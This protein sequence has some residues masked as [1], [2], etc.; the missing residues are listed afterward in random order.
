ML[1]EKLQAALDKKNSDITRYV[2]KGRK[3]EVNGQYV[4]TEKRL[5]DCSESE[6]KSFYAHCES[7]LH[8]EN[9]ENPGRHVLLNIVK[10]QI[11][12]CNAELFLRY[13]AEEPRKMPKFVF[14]TKIRE[15]LNNNPH[16]DPKEYPIST[17]VGSC[18][19]EYADIPI[20]LVMDG[21]LERLG[22]FERKH[23]TLTFI[24]KQGIWFTPA[25]SKEI[26]EYREKYNSAEKAK[27]IPEEDKRYLADKGSAAKHYLGLNTSVALKIN[28]KGL[29]LAQM[30]AMI[31]LTSAKYS[32]LTTVQLTTLRNRMLFALEDEVKF[33]IKQWETREAQILEVAE[34]QGFSILPSE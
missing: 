9:K 21:C 30:R 33:H 3:E 28:P 10:D 18:P 27:N 2:W 34:A 7:M 15:I 19:E 23:I 6:L 8:N 1:R 25:E 26:T 20:D 29:S 16:V 5:V 24:L 12:R 31:K 14:L 22:K 13:M 11:V 4:Q 17:I 32:D